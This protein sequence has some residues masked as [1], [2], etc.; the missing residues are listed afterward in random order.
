MRGRAGFQVGK[1]YVGGQIDY[2]FSDITPEKF[3]AVPEPTDQDRWTLRFFIGIDLS[4]S[5]R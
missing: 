4:R 5:G 1:F 2:F 3:G